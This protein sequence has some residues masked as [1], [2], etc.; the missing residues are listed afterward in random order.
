VPTRIKKKIF[1]HVIAP[2]TKEMLEHQSQDTE[3]FREMT[4]IDKPYFG[5]NNKIILY[6]EC[7]IAIILDNEKDMS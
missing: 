4:L 6:D 2:N 7:K 5:V 1:I 3:S